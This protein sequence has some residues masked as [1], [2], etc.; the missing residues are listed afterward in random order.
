MDH[1]EIVDDLKLDLLFTQGV[2]PQIEAKQRQSFFSRFFNILQ[3]PQ[4]APAAMLLLISG[5][6]IGLFIGQKT[7][8]D[9]SYSPAAIVERLPIEITRSTDNQLPDGRIFLSDKRS[10]ILLQLNIHALNERYQ[11]YSVE[12]KHSDKQ[13]LLDSQLTSNGV[14]EVALDSSELVPGNIIVNVLGT[15]VNGDK[16]IIKRYSIEALQE[17]VN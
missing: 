10:I 16:S 12:I 7:I 9:K 17:S 1:P 6:G 4:F 3:Q 15:T 8:T 11:N 14:I 2:Q 5:T 13:Y